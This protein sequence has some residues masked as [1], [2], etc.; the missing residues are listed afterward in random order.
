MRQPEASSVRTASRARTSS[1]RLVSWVELP[2]MVVG[3]RRARSS[4]AAWN[5]PSVKPKCAG[6]PPTSFSAISRL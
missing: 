6:W 4:A 1:E 5:S 3:Q 2:S